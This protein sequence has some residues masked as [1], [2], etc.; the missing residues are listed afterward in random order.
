MDLSVIILSYNTRQLL[1]SCL[2]TVFNS[3]TDYKFEVLVPDNGSTDRSQEMVRQEFPQVKLVENHAN[4]GFA[5]GNN[6]ALRLA[7]GRYWLLLN[8]DTEVNAE[9]FDLS[10]K[11]MDA[12]PD[13]GAMGCKVLLQNGELDKAAR[14]KFPNPVN[15][16]LRLFGMSKLSD[17]NITTPID[18]EVEV[19]AVVGA[20][21]TVPKS[22]IDKVGLLDEEYF[23]YGEDL[24]WCWRIKEAGF[25][26]MYYPTPSI[27]HLK[28]AS[29]KKIAFK[30]IRWAHAAM[31][32]FYRKHYSQKHNWLFNQFIYLGINL[33]MFLVL[34]MNLIKKKTTIH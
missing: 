3:K 5:K 10:I 18:Q 12:H 17:Y 20:Y 30:V 27:L 15:A 8:S 13:V 28:S 25:K 29:S 4:L 6:V 21:M 7:Q 14:R 19:D 32:I 26:I 31:K 23:M 1:R 33:R 24:D 16:F 22:V 2:K 34:F 9:T 11:Y